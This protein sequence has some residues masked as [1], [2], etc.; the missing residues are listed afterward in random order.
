MAN[1]SPVENVLTVPAAIAL[2][3]DSTVANVAAVQ[4]QYKSIGELM[5]QMQADTAIVGNTGE[6]PGTMLVRQ[7]GQLESELQSQKLAVEAG[8]NPDMAIDIRAIMLRDIRDTGLK[9]RDATA[10]LQQQKSVSLFDDPVEA[11]VN[12]FVIPWT[13]QEISGYQVQQAAAKKTLEDITSGVT[14]SAQAQN[15]IK[16]S[17]TAASIDEQYTAMQGVV[18]NQKRRIGIE[19]LQ[20]NIHQID[21]QMKA[22]HTQLTYSIEMNRWLNDERNFKILQ[23]QRDLQ[24]RQHNWM[25]EERT[26][27]KKAMEDRLGYVNLA[28]D[29]IKA[30]RIATIYELDARLTTA[31]GKAI[32]DDLTDKGRVLADSRYAASYTD[33][34]PSKVESYVKFWQRSGKQWT[35]PDERVFSELM[36]TA[37]N[38]GQA[39]KKEGVELTAAQFLNK[40]FDERFNTVKR[41]DSTNPNR[42]QTFETM[43]Q[44]A[45]LTTDQNFKRIFT[46]VISP[47]IT[48]ANK[49]VS[50]HPELVGPMVVK[51]VKS[52]TIKPNDA[53]MFLAD[54]YTASVNIATANSKVFEWTGKSFTNFKTDVDGG[55]TIG[56]AAAGLGLLGAAAVGGTVGL[57]VVGVLG[58][59]TTAVIGTAG[60]ATGIQNAVST[61]VT[62]DWTDPVMTLSYIIRKGFLGSTLLT[63]GDTTLPTTKATGAPTK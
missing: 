36:I 28:L 39:H 18:A 45:E 4:A 32:I 26:N 48:D 61:R 25:Q 43:A 63:P 42:A 22:D 29:K 10:R 37:Y 53:A 5:S 54:F 52:G 56:R 60:I 44:R 2:S 3:K 15:A 51:A 41:D 16:T 20:N 46:A 31:E 62:L 57:P 34:D 11:V 14:A 30:P 12:A 13:E 8:F 50:T 23:Q 33:G 6:T 24:L 27:K 17:V 49:A 1:T 55:A 59:T 21:F 19:A 35:N 7:T 40:S 38:N 58:A 9:M 47:Q